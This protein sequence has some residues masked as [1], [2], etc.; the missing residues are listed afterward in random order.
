MINVLID[1]TGNNIILRRFISAWYECV[2]SHHFLRNSKE[3][4]FLVL[5]VKNEVWK[6][7]IQAQGD[8]VIL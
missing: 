5:V 7:I 2:T 1:V 4:L 8:P 6:P 3:S